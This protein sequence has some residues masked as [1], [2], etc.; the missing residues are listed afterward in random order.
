M[1]VLGALAIIGGIANG[2]CA[3]LSCDIVSIVSNS[4]TIGLILGGLVLWSENS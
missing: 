2:S 1:M 3:T 4:I